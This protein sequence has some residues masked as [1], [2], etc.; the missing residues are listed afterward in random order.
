MP[1]NLVMSLFDAKINIFLFETL[2]GSRLTVV[3]LLVF[4]R[5]MIFLVARL[6]SVDF[7]GAI[8]LFVC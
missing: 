3:L 2:L 6:G 5:M 1:Y 8:F 4:V 7:L